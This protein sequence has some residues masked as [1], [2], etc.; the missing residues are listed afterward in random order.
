MCFLLDRECEQIQLEIFSDDFE[1]I[2][3]NILQWIL[4]YNLM[5]LKEKCQKLK[6]IFFLFLFL[7]TLSSSIPWS[8]SSSY[9]IFCSY[10]FYLM[11]V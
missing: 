1:Y 8:L 7:K 9:G 10:N 3:H 5:I 4:A 11:Y 6:L 2:Y